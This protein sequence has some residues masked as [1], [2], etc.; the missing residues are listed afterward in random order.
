MFDSMR[1][2]GNKIYFNKDQIVE[3]HEI[4]YS[5]YLALV[6]H[7]TNKHANFLKKQNF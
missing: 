1:Y 6:N 4:T 2:D 3:S 7:L 5:G